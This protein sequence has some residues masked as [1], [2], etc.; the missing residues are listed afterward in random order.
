MVLQKISK[1]LARSE[2]IILLDHQN[3]YVGKLIA[4]IPKLFAALLTMLVSFLRNYFVDSFFPTT[5]F[6]DLYL[7]KFLD[8]RAKSFF[9]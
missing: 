4:R 2:S 1:N 9:L 6:S 5:L 8:T 3:N 7:A